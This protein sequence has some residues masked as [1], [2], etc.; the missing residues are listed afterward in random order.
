MY[1]CMMCN[2]YI[3]THA[4]IYIIHIY[5]MNIYVFEE[6]TC[7]YV[8]QYAYTLL[9]TLNI[10]TPSPNVMVVGGGV[11]RDDQVMMMYSS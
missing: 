11:L 4:H 9:W 8:F 5:I 3:Y 1:A 10:Y 2:I 6:N 7:I